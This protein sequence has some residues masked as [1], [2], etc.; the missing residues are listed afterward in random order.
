MT[1]ELLA[2]LREL[3]VRLIEAQPTETLAELAK[4]SGSDWTAM[5]LG[6]LNGIQPSH[7]FEGGELVKI[8]KAESYRPE[9]A[10]WA[11]EQP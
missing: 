2:E 1:R 7:R 8:T 4:R 10:A 6:V 3:R 11:D 5:Q 9:G